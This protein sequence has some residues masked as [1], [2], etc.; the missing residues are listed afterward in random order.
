MYAYFCLSLYYE[1]GWDKHYTQYIP[2]F[3]SLANSCSQ[4]RGVAEDIQHIL[5]C[6]YQNGFALMDADTI[7]VGLTP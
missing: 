2:S 4:E 3:F 1:Y 5:A 6:R 7:D